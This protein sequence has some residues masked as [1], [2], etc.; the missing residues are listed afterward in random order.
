[1]KAGGSTRTRGVWPVLMLLL[2]SVFFLEA[3]ATRQQ[4]GRRP[5][6][7]IFYHGTICREDVTAPLV[8]WLGRSSDLHNLDGGFLEELDR[9]VLATLMSFD[10][11]ENG[12][13]FLSPGN[14]GE[15]R[16]DIRLTCPALEIVD[17]T[18]MLYLEFQNRNA[19]KETCLPPCASSV[20]LKVPK[21]DY[22]HIQARD[23]KGLFMMKIRV[24]ET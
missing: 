5:E 3:C 18:A 13:L 23:E 15:E 20:L 12:I 7:S 6:V 17:N 1:M 8:A 14:R 21:G 11:K 16:Y 22:H 10:F 9:T 2:V 19:E 24:P 4:E